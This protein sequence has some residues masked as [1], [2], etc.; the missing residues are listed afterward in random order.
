[1]KKCEQLTRSRIQARFA[2]TKAEVPQDISS[3]FLR[4]RMVDVHGENKE[5]MVI[6]ENGEN[7]SYFAYR[8]SKKQSVPRDTRRAI[9]ETQMSVNAVVI[10]TDEKIASTH[11]C[12]SRDLSHAAGRHRRKRTSARR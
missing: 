8:P 12:I 4:A 10:L 1:M 11:R 5:R 9:W 2:R 6:T 3:M 7:K